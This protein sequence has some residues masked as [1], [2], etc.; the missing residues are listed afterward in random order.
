MS[1]PKGVLY[2]DKPVGPTSHDAVRI[3]RKSL[4]ERRIGHTGTLDPFATGLLILLVGPA[5]R[6]AE[7]FN[8]LEKRYTAVV[9]LGVETDTHDHTGEAVARFEGAQRVTRSQ[10]EDALARQT[11]TIQQLPPRYSAKK[12]A[13]EAA[14]RRVRRGEDVELAAA[15]VT[16]HSIKI[17]RFAPPEIE[18]DIV[19]STGTYV[20]S[21]AHDLGQDLGVGGHLIAL[22][23]TAIG[24]YSTESALDWEALSDPDRTLEGLVATSHGLSHLSSVALNEEDKAFIN[25]GR[26]VQ[27]GDDTVDLAFPVVAL[28]GD[29]VL[30]VGEVREGLFHPKKVFP[31][32]A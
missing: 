30:S 22:R 29:V 25:T 19:C 7:T 24:P 20:R 32:G 6:L 27:A 8:T 2:V 12:V 13:G 31:D 5:T 28:A 14:H 1:N 10:V 4:R 21:I 23:R 15:E 3:A 16:V 18:L 17:V 11:G 26:A 9:M